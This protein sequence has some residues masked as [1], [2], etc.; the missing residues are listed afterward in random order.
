MFLGRVAGPLIRGAVD[1]T[2]NGHL[3]SHIVTVRGWQPYFWAASATVIDLARIS[4]RK[5]KSLI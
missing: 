4:W 1:F 5:A 2:P 3:V